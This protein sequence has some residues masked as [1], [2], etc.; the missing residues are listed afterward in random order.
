[1]MYFVL[2]G[3]TEIFLDISELAGSGKR[4]YLPEKPFLAGEY[5]LLFLSKSELLRAPVSQTSFLF[6]LPSPRGQQ[7]L[8]TTF[9]HCHLKPFPLITDFQV[10]LLLH[11]LPLPDKLLFIF[12]FSFFFTICLSFYYFDYFSLVNTCHISQFCCTHEH[13]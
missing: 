9:S 4:R 11:I 5:L 3:K 1:M 8:I 6:S 7:R 10:L 2:Q 13:N 12:L